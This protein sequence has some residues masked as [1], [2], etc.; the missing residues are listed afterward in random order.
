LL[1]P[2]QR[3]LAA[4]AFSQAFERQETREEHGH[5]THPDGDYPTADH[6]L[7]P[8]NESHRVPDS[9]DEEDQAGDKTE[10][11]LAHWLYASY[12]SIG[13]LVGRI[14]LLF[15]KTLGRGE[16]TCRPLLVA[17]ALLRDYILDTRKAF[18]YSFLVLETFSN[19][20]MCFLI[21]EWPFGLNKCRIAS[22]LVMSFGC[23]FFFGIR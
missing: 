10:C 11:L 23:F 15:E 19:L 4:P 22:S 13:K 2:C 7:P 5:P 18:C 12:E 6:R 16:L 20:A 21:R 14:L 9:D 1:L 3:I 17:Q 8:E